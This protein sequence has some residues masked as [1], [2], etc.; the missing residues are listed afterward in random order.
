MSANFLDVLK[1]RIRRTPDFM[2]LRDKTNIPVFLY[3]DFIYNTDYLYPREIKSLGKAVTVANNLVYRKRYMEQMKIGD[4]FKT[5]NIRG[6]HV[7]PFKYEEGCV[8]GHVYLLNYKALLYL[9][10]WYMNREVFERKEIYVFLEDQESPF[11]TKTDIRLKTYFYE[12]KTS[13][14]NNL[15]FNMNENYYP[16]PN[17]LGT[18][19]YFSSK[20][21]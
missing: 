3:E 1:Q 20:T 15:S 11:K 10:E 16:S 18:R 13:Q 21:Y 9:D 8:G 2:E 17:I 4:T 12:V 14:I 5:M 6:V 7:S 19:R